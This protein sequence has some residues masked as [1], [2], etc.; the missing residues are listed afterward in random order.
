VIIELGDK[1]SSKEELLHKCLEKI[2]KR[3]KMIH[4]LVNKSLNKTAESQDV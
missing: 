4:F 1:L 3:K 2:A